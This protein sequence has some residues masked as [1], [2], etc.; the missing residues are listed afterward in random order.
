MV[1]TPVV[2]PLLTLRLKVNAGPSGDHVN[3]S[4]IRLIG[5]VFLLWCLGV[6]LVVG[7]LVMQRPRRGWDDLHFPMVWICV[8]GWVLDVVV[9]VWFV[10]GGGDIY[11][12]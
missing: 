12:R 2:I 4:T 3:D 5:E 7:V 10:G 6:I 8:V 9:V 1:D 11:A